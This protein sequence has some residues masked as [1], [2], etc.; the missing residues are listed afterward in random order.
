MAGLSEVA[1]SSS[2]P[3]EPDSQLIS[4]RGGSG[5]KP[6][7]F[8]STPPQ[9]RL[10]GRRGGERRRGRGRGTEGSQN[11][12]GGD[13]YVG[14]ILEGCLAARSGILKEVRGGRTGLP[15][16]VRAGRRDPGCGRMQRGGAERPGSD[17][18]DQRFA[19]DR[20]EGARIEMR[21]EG[22]EDGHGGES[23]RRRAV[24]SKRVWEI[25]R[26]LRRRTGEW[27]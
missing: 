20:A 18:A 2:T 9:Q 13:V 19:T 25:R 15:R 12:A 11:K 24:E 27:N 4:P 5:G 16:D 14:T 17:R 26:M 6:I 21:E 8:E 22:R 10:G 3:A 23:G 1:P 7:K